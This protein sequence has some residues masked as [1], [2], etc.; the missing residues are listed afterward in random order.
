MNFGNYSG[1]FGPHEERGK[2]T[3]AHWEVNPK[4]GRTISSGRSLKQRLI[5]TGKHGGSSI[6][7]NMEHAKH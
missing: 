6:T 4:L 7:K 1:G 2:Q 5:R 3:R